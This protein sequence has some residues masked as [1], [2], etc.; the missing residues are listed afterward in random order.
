MRRWIKHIPGLAELQ[1]LLVNDVL[2]GESFIHT[3]N[4]G[5]AAGLRF[6]VTL[7]LDKAIWAGVYET[8]FAEAISGAVR[9][10]DV[11]YDIGGYR[12]YMSGVMALAGA[13]SVLVFE[14]LPANQRALERLCQLNPK[15]SIELKPVAISNI[16]GSLRLHVMADASM[17]KLVT[18]PFQA[19]APATGDIEVPV[20]SLDSLVLGQE[21]PPPQLM[22]IDVEGAEI[23][24]LCGAE[25]ILR[26]CRPLIFLEAHSASLEEACSQVLTR[27]DYSVRRLESRSLND[28]RARHLIASPR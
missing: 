25:G 7:P 28:E 18:S 1:R 16:D 5:P 23:D 9:S 12:G 2:S 14:P 27:Y 3:I 11:C 15:L 8:E 10:G 4:A 6:E 19:A 13:S 20:R 26:D 22:K 21:A 17:G 24:V